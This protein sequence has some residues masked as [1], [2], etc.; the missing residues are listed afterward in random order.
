MKFEFGTSVKNPQKNR[1]RT[2]TQ[3][4]RMS[5]NHSHPLGVVLSHRKKDPRLRA[6]IREALA[7]GFEKRVSAEEYQ[8]MTLAQTRREWERK[9]LEAAKR[10]IALPDDCINKITALY[11]NN[12]NDDFE[13][14][15]LKL[16][17][18]LLQ[19]CGISKTQSPS[20]TNNN[21][22]YE[23][24]ALV[25]DYYE[26]RAFL[27][28]LN[29]KNNNDALKFFRDL[30]AVHSLLLN[31]DNNNDDRLARVVAVRI[32]QNPDKN[33]SVHKY[34]HKYLGRNY[35]NDK[36]FNPITNPKPTKRRRPPVASST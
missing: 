3:L 6:K 28:S 10:K 31:P 33:S 35:A 18:I 2:T 27:G 29:L 9:R 20:A 25:N 17:I 19:H 21:L 1:R 36:I 7:D 30:H 34:L 24:A 4:E 26:K 14:R 12:N 8:R 11:K 13:S 5:R 32:L 22:K 23:L 15:R 16:L